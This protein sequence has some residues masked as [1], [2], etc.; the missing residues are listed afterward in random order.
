[1]PP[2]T[3]VRLRCEKA[4]TQTTAWRY[5]GLALGPPQ[6]GWP[7]RLCA[8]A[9]AAT[10]PER[11]VGT[12]QRWAD[13]RARSRLYGRSRTATS[14]AAS[15]TPCLTQLDL[16][17]VNGSGIGR[18]P[19]PERDIGSL[20]LPVL[21]RSARRGA[22]PAEAASARRL[23][24][25]RQRVPFLAERINRVCVAARQGH[26]IAAFASQRPRSPASTGP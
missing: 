16:L 10:R 13:R 7:G 2:D 20:N 5:A 12:R 17:S 8:A 24:L 15:P 26:G 21:D 19:G 11:W 18:A 9:A 14:T 3:R 22:T 23:H 4:D 1:M 6:Y 25:T